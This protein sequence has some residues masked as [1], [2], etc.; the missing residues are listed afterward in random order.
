MFK[1]I[2]LKAGYFAGECN[3]ACAKNFDENGK[4][5]NHFSRKGIRFTD[6]VK[7]D[8]VAQVVE[9]G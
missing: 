7:K 9:R 8:A 6:E 3:Q 1:K 5:S 4:N 2:W